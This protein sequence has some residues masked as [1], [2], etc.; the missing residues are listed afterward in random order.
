MRLM[1]VTYL[2]PAFIVLMYFNKVFKRKDTR[3]KC[4]DCVLLVLSF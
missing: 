1:R 2:S 3:I 4:L